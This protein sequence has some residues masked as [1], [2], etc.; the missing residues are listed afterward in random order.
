MP[1][2]SVLVALISET[3]TATDRPRRL[4]ALIL[5]EVLRNGRDLSGPGSG[6]EVVQPHEAAA[7]ADAMKDLIQRYNLGGDDAPLGLDR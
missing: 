1:S 5:V 4:A 3:V 6:M 7:V 2:D